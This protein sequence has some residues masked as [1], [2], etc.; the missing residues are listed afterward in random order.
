MSDF[1]RMVHKFTIRESNTFKKVCEPLHQLLGVKHFWYC[2]TTP[3]GAFFSV[4]SN[5]ELH[6]YYHAS[7]QH[8]HSPFFHNPKHIRPGFYSYPAIDDEKFQKS[9]ACCGSKFRVTFGG[10]FVVHREKCMIR[11][12]YA[13]DRSVGNKAGEIILNNIPILQKF[14]DHFL[15]ETKILLQ[16]ARDDAVSLPQEIGQIYHQKPGGLGSVLSIQE[17]C[18]FLER[19]GF[20]KSENVKKLT[21]R[22]LECLQYLHDGNCA[23][24]IA[25]ILHISPRTVEKYF[26]SI[27]NK[28]ICYTKSE[29]MHYANLL[30]TAG[31]F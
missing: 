12:G 2:E 11:F 27:K 16:K 25:G 21:L 15:K 14:N 3:D 17:K 20:L 30:H 31:F 22:E 1:N 28:L 9:F 10:S 7:K 23:R 24:E 29:L 19:I 18:A 6:E 5:P 8:L 26:E 13:F 4:A